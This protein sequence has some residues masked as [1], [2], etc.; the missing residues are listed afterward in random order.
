[1]DAPPQ[2]QAAQARA[3]SNAM[4]RMHRDSYGRGATSVKTVIQRGF[5]ISFLEDIYTPLER[6]LID[7]GDADIVM[8]TRLAFQNA[9]REEFIAIVEGATGRKVRAFLSQ[10]HIAPDL[11]AEVFV[12]ETNGQEPSDVENTV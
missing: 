4:T 3:I 11:A 6:T 5:V 8:T 10:N 12:L 7:A 9:K 2:E 1:M